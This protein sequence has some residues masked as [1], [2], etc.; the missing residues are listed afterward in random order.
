[1]AIACYIE[2]HR[3]LA[4]YQSFIDV[5]SRFEYVKM[6][7]MAGLQTGAIYYGYRL[8]LAT[9]PLPVLYWASHNHE[10]IL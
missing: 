9:S 2:M 7:R 3:R 5:R 10:L 8:L 4:G 6:R 1:M